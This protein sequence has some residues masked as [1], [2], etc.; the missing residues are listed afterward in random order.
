[1]NKKHNTGK[2]INTFIIQFT[3]QFYGYYLELME[4]MA[5]LSSET[6]KKL[7]SKI[8]SRIP[9]YKVVTIVKI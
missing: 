4:L 7:T 3:C 9:K 5:T 6:S 8:D 1:M 2:T